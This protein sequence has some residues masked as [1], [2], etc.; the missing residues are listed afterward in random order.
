MI[1]PT[2]MGPVTPVVKK[3]KFDPTT[4]HVNHT[5]I[6]G[7]LI[8]GVKKEDLKE[9][10]ID[11]TALAKS[12]SELILRFRKT[13][14]ELIVEFKAANGGDVVIMGRQNNVPY[15]GTYDKANDS[16]NFD[17]LDLP[18]SLVIILYHFAKMTTGN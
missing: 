12:L 7:Q 14:L 9:Y 8:D 3:F 1:K 17:L 10:E 13:V 6:L 2:V 4:K 5:M 15:R 18:P 11:L 16:S